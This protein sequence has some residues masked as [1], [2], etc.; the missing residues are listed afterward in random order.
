MQRNPIR[1]SPATNA[2]SAVAAVGLSADTGEVHDDRPRA[3]ERPRRLKDSRTIPSALHRKRAANG[4]D[5]QLQPLGGTLS[6]T[7]PAVP[8]ALIEAHR[9]AKAP[10]PIS[11]F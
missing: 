7:D 8:I 10:S 3:R 11:V 1:H 9:R 2:N 6:T 4:G 5:S